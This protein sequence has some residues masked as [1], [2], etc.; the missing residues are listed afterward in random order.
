MQSTMH[1]EDQKGRIQA[2]RAG[3][4]FFVHTLVALDLG[5]GLMFLGYLLN[6]PGASQVLVL[7]VSVWCRFWWEA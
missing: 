6:P 3:L 5:A 7:F 2:F 4:S 1:T